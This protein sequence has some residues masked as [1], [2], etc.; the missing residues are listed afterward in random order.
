MTGLTYQ[1]SIS[2]ALFLLFACFTY[3]FSMRDEWDWNTCQK[4][5][6]GLVYSFRSSQGSPDVTNYNNLT[7]ESG[8]Q[9]DSWLYL[10]SRF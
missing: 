8:L 3:T 5:E 10:L 6:M 9:F 4:K 1:N 7:S 2:G